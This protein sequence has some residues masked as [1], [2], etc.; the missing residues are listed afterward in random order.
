MT[1]FRP[2]IKQLLIWG[3]LLAPISA[4]ALPDLAIGPF[5]P[6]TVDG[7]E[8]FNVFGNCAN[9]AAQDIQGEDCGDNNL[10]VRNQDTVS[11]IWSITADNYAPGAENLK[12]VTVQQTITPSPTATI[13]FESIPVACTPIAGGGTAPPSEIVNNN[14]GSWTLLCNLG[15]FTEGE[16]KSLTVNVKISGK[17]ANGSTY[18]STQRVYSLDTDGNP[19]ANEGVSSPVGPLLISASPA[20]DLVSSLSPTHSM[21]TN[22]IGKRDV[23]GDGTPELGF[24]TYKLLRL[25]A[26]R[27]TG[28]EAIQQPIIFDDVFN[29]KATTENGADYALEMYITEC[30]DNPSG[31]K[32]EIYGDET[33]NPAYDQGSLAYHAI[34]SGT[35]NYERVDAN[36]N[37]SNDPTSHYFRVTLDDV[38]LSGN[39]YPTKAFGS[40]DLRSGPYYAMS[41]RVQ[42][43]TPF[44]SVDM[45]D[46]VMDNQ[47]TVYLYSVLN[48]FDPDGLSGTSNYGA[49]VEPGY[50]GAEMNNLR[51]NNRISVPL[52]LTV[53]GS[54]SKRNL[55][56]ARDTMTNY[57]YTGT[58]WHGGDGEVEAGNTFVGWVQYENNGTLALDNP[59]ACDIFDN[60]TQQL[61]DRGETGAT[62]GTYAYVGTY[63]PNGFDYNNYIVEYA[64][65]DLT[66]DDPLDEDHDGTKDYDSVSG[67]YHGDWE[68]A[69]ALR[70]DDATPTAGWFTDPTQVPGGIDAVNAVRVKLSDTAKANG[71]KFE[72]AQQMR[73]AIPLKARD[74]FN[75]GPYAGESIPV[76][77]VLANFGSVRSD[78][79]APTWTSR[80]YEASPETGHTD[81]DRVTLTR[82][83]LALDSESLTPPAS[84]GNT[85]ST[86]AG[87]PIVWKVTSAVQST[88]AQPSD[89][90][91]LHIISILPPETTYNAT[92]TAE[93][94]DATPANLV[95][96]NTDKDGNPAP[97]Y[98]RLSWNFGDVTANTLIPPRIFCS[99]TDPLALHGTDIPLYS[100]IRAGNTITAL[101]RRSDTHTIKLEQTGSIQVSKA[102]DVPLDPLNDDQVYT[103][104]WANFAPAFTINEPT[105]IDV[106][107]FMSGSGDGEG[108]LSPRIPTS[109]FHGDLK[110]QGEP[111]ISWLDDSTPSG[112]DPHATMGTWYYSANAPET[113]DFNPDANTAAGTTTWCLQNDFG[114]ANCPADFGEVTAIKFISNY[115]LAKDGNPRQG[116]K[117]SYTLQAGDTINQNSNNANKAGDLYTNRFTFDST[118]LPPDQYLR[119]NNVSVKVAAFSIGDFVFADL[120]DNGKFDS[121]IDTTVPDGIKIE[122]YDASND[123]KLAETTTG[124]LGAGRYLFEPFATGSYYIRIP[125]SEFQAGAKLD[126]WTLAPYTGDGTENDDHN[127][128]VDQHGYSESGL[129]N[130]GVR[131]KSITL[132][133]NPPQPGGLP[134]GNEPIGD[135][136]LPITDPTGDDFSNLTLDIGLIPP[137]VTDLS[138][139]KTANSA[140]GNPGDN[141]T[142]T[143]EV[144][145]HGIRPA[146]D[147]Q[148]QD[149]LPEK[150]QYVSATGGDSHSESNGIVTWIISQIAANTTTTLTITALV[151]P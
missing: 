112:S 20:Y 113:I 1:A 73:F 4:H 72:P 91:N 57:A 107:S 139:S 48:D 45:A 60:T 144:V 109:N 94:T 116:M 32:G 66:G 3:I 122:L 14:D 18:T 28:I 99:D 151:L 51:G 34:D 35:C 80:N 142:F 115:P 79:W 11:H 78:N 44:R 71:I 145:N 148:I 100:E 2:V 123:T 77:T 23:D 130:T 97:G 83:Q 69:K 110:L 147:V 136:V 37:P 25:A 149:M 59:M 31:W 75:G 141:V 53:R 126:G 26:A 39:R 21:Y 40:I 27:K 138:L 5:G 121:D 82:L 49:G 68:V 114:N 33:Y 8:P 12:N 89:A 81:G 41:Q 90:T 63:A 93:Q 84:P 47:G 74:T 120:N 101:S 61:V 67:R 56:W 22:Y 96:Y 118:S 50:N 127:E 6:G 13:S 103:I 98:T 135:N 108:S 7:G 105:I 19:N 150:L 24:Y 52:H 131:T 86:L 70:C 65:V 134:T 111:T 29:A 117:A 143:L 88:L 132:D 146:I 92:C 64:S 125:A 15:E 54:F 137:R 9:D 140:S 17:S 124:T 30:R 38:D 104:S 87:Q 62:A 85:A 129:T 10:V 102:V 36:G 119:S 128:H 46:G 42:I 16:Q 133:A 95:E 43:F 76:G 106:F 55:K 58:S